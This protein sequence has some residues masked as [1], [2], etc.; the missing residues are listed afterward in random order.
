[1]AG[2]DRSRPVASML[3]ISRGSCRC[4]EPRERATTILTV[5]E[6]IQVT[7]PLPGRSSYIQLCKQDRQNR[8]SRQRVLMFL[9]GSK[10]QK[11][12]R[13]NSLRIVQPPDRLLLT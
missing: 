12:R 8:K 2:R 10:R 11:P 4:E 7:Q 13:L 1:E 3:A 6:R 9:R 5:A